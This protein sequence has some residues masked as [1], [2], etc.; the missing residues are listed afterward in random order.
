[1]KR[2]DGGGFRMGKLFG[3]WYSPVFICTALPQPSPVPSHGSGHPTLWRIERMQPTKWKLRSLQNNV[4]VK[5]KSVAS[6]ACSLLLQLL[7]LLSYHETPQENKEF[8]LLKEEAKSSSKSSRNQTLE[9][10]AMPEHTLRAW[11][12]GLAKGPK[13]A[14]LKLA[15]PLPHPP[16]IS[17]HL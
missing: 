8:T 4:V 14:T 17:I 7:P 6:P 9:G 11:G 5:S 16:L 12:C 1:M 3:L 15:A 2:A 10:A 13:G